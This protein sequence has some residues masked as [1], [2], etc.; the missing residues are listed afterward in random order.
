[1]EH[2]ERHGCRAL[3]PK[4]HG[5]ALG[6]AIR[7]MG[8]PLWGTQSRPRAGP[9]GPLSGL[10]VGAREDVSAPIARAADS[11]HVRVQAHARGHLP[12]ACYRVGQG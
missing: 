9:V 8:A 1:M 5:G 3:R 4:G 6:Y 10:P 2:A 11:R 12:A 7:R